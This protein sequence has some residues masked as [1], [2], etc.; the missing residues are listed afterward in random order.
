MTS[1]AT[2]RKH[3][4]KVRLNNRGLKF[5]GEILTFYLDPIP[6]VGELMAIVLPRYGRLPLIKG[7]VMLVYHEVVP[8]KAHPNPT[9]FV[10][11][12]LAV[13][14]YTTSQEAQQ[15]LEGLFD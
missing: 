6:Q 3:L 4:C 10:F 11:I 13:L 8:A 7:T 15:E 5:D 1:D 9:Q 2:P 12:N 14:D